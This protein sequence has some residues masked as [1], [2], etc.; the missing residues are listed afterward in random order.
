[1]KWRAHCKW[2][3]SFIH[4]NSV[5]P[6]DLGDDTL[7]VVHLEAIRAEFVADEELFEIGDFVPPDAIFQLPAVQHDIHIY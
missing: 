3:L 4:R 7:C 2:G 6:R 1:M 5:L